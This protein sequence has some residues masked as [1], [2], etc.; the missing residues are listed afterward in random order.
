[1]HKVSGQTHG[2]TTPQSE[3]L[4]FQKFKNLNS[5]LGNG[6]KT[7]TSSSAQALA[8][9]NKDVFPVLTTDSKRK[10]AEDNANHINNTKTTSAKIDLNTQTSETNAIIVE[11]MSKFRLR[12]RVMKA[13]DVKK[14]LMDHEFIPIQSVQQHITNLNKSTAARFPELIK[15]G[16]KIETNPKLL[17]YWATVGVLESSPQ[18][19]TTSTKKKYCLLR[20]TNLV[21]VQVNILLF[22]QTYES[23]YRR[24]QQGMVIGIQK[25]KVLRPTELDT[26]TGLHVDRVD[27]IFI[28]GWSKDCAQCE[29]YL[30]DGSQCS[31]VIDGR[32][33]IY[34]EEH[35][36]FAYKRSK[37]TRMELASGDVAL[38]IR[39]ATESKTDQ[40][41][42]VYRVQG[43]IVKTQKRSSA[44]GTKMVPQDNA[45]YVLDGGGIVTNSKTTTDLL[46]AN[47]SKENKKELADF[48]SAR[49]DFGARML[50]QTTG[51]VNTLDESAQES[52]KGGSAFSAEAIRRIGFNP[53]PS[54][55]QLSRIDK[56]QKS[57]AIDRLLRREK[58]KPLPSGSQQALTSQPKEKFVYL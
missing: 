24:L 33:G 40:G 49:N 58:D 21:D 54:A 3:D 51:F 36:M 48:L 13:Q 14:R 43:G 20:L 29:A 39:A 46:S 8:S 6:K 15:Y 12:E 38:E 1:M 11:P 2:S 4:V 7:I 32:N 25:P 30:R 56:D 9:N 10:C 18:E 26:T 23:W 19:R 16:K 34:C 42:H 52:A 41:R 17:E 37:N 28:I 27:N 22:G 35:V 31:T 45:A 44:Y 57:Q 47:Y 5:K 53:D 50:R 55:G